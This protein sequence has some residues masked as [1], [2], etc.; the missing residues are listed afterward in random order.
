MRVSES[1]LLSLMRG[2][3]SPPPKRAKMP[4]IPRGSEIPNFFA[5]HEMRA[6][7]INK[8]KI[9]SAIFPIKFPLLGD[10]VLYK[11]GT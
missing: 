6:K 5:P 7:I 4:K 8:Y 2:S 9:P 10:F 1:L 11:K 3:Y